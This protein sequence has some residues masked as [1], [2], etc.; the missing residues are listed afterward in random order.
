MRTRNWKHRLLSLTMCL[1]LALSLLPSAVLA[2]GSGTTSCT[3]TYKANYTGGTDTTASCTSGESVTLA[4]A[5]VRAGYAFTEWNTTADGSGAAYAAGAT[6]TVT[7]D[8]PLYAQWTGNVHTVTFNIQGHGVAP[9]DQTAACGSTVTE[10][11]APTQTGY[12][13]GG[14]YK[15][16]ACTTPWN[17]STDTMPASN[18]TLYAKWTAYGYT[19]KFA[20]ETGGTLSGTTA[21]QSVAYGGNASGACTQTAAADYT[22]LGWSYNYT[23]A[24]GQPHAGVVPDYSTVPV[25]G[26]MS[27]KA[28]YAKTLYVSVT[29]TNGLVNIA[30]GMN[31]PDGSPSSPKAAVD[32]IAASPASATIKYA[33]INSSYD[34]APTITVTGSSS[35]TTTL[36]NG[37]TTLNGATIQV[38]NAQGYIIVTN[39]TE[40]LAFSVTFAP[41]KA[42]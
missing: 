10:P 38:D 29:A 11:T 31:L 23:G 27:F 34:A 25:Y 15:E 22:F 37:N 42:S 20:T 39:A 13:F 3:V 28:T 17:F 5:P 40:S 12:A 24:D 2:D 26:D 7:A 6:L 21:D 32:S 30:S 16:A 33:P 35:G 36:P 1:I 41:I 9:S 19:V 4:S 8:T 14:W 18:L